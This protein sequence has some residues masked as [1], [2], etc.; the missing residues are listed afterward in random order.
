M[1]QAARAATGLKGRGIT[2]IVSSPLSR[3][4]V[5]AETVGLVLG[6]PVEID[7]GLS[8]VRFGV[9][10]GQPMAPWFPDWIAGTFTPQGGETF[11][12]LTARATTALARALDRPA[13]V[14]VVGHGAFF[15]AVRA[16]LGLDVHV[17][18]PNAAPILAE[19]PGPGMPTWRL[20][21]LDGH[22]LAM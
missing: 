15:R 16:A 7:P 8:E 13:P 18:T 2:T 12:E 5:T 17:R 10:E 3:A 6:L 4:R 9:Q 20:T 22:A 21:A 19:P 14:L 11:A 1:A